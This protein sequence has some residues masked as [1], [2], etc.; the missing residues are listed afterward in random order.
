[1]KAILWGKYKQTIRKPGAFIII[2]LIC[3]VFSFLLGKSS[4]SKIEVPV[5]NEGSSSGLQSIL[6]ELNKSDSYSFKAYSLKEMKKKVEEGKSAAGLKLGEDSYTLI[7]VA[8]T[9]DV[10]LI[11]RYVEKYYQNKQQKQLLLASAEKQDAEKIIDENEKKPI[12]TISQDSVISQKKSSYNQSLQALFGFT[13]FFSIY[14]VAYTV[15]EILRDKQN[16]LWDRFI[17]SST[18]KTQLYLGH[19]LFSFI[20]GYIQMIII[21]SIFNYGVGVDFNGKFY[22]I[23]I[24][25]VPYLYAIVSLAILLTGLVKTASQFNSIIPLISVSFAMLGG[26][27]WPLEIVTSKFLLLLSKF[28]PITYGMD[29]LKTAI[30]QET[31]W[32]ELMLPAAVLLLMGTLMLG[33]GIRLMEKRHV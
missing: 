10:M 29:L 22:W 12:L 4:F 7:R 6:Q 20:I 21:F 23:F 17:L 18:S 1:M 14:T 5:F 9:A 26:A 24:L 15:V 25:I 19:L 8:D 27:Y 32:S 31:S 16:G 28:I 30:I 3:V 11:N 13:L 2:T 33:V